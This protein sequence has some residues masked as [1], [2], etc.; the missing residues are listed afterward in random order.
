[1]SFGQQNKLFPP[2]SY[3]YM[4]QTIFIPE[5]IPVFYKG[6]IYWILVMVI[7]EYQPQEF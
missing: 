4:N 3:L 5:N 1:M 2:S 6:V 7:G